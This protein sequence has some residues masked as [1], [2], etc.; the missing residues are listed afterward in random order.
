VAAKLKPA[1]EKSV[2]WVWETYVVPFQQL[3]ESLKPLLPGKTVTLYLHNSLE[4]DVKA[5][6]EGNIIETSLA[7]REE[8]GNYIVAVRIGGVK[9][10]IRVFHRGNKIIVLRGAKKILR[11]W[12]VDEFNPDKVAEEIAVIIRGKQKG[13]KEGESEG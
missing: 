7:P 6:R 13:K 5:D 4:L 3:K 2:R 1:I 10:N 9:P 8:S 12:S 11:E